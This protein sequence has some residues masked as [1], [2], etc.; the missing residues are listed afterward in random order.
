M[1]TTKLY[2]INSKNYKSINSLNALSSGLWSF[3]NLNFQD[4]DIISVYIS[5]LHAEIP[6]SFYIINENNNKLIIN[7]ITY[8]LIPG[9]YNTK[10]FIE[11]VKALLPIGYI[12]TY[13][14]TT[15]KFTFQYTTLFT[16]SV[17]STCKNIVGLSSS[18]VLGTVENNFTV[19]LPNSFNFLPTAKINIRSSSFNIGNFGAD[20]STDIFLT[21]QNNGLQS[22]RILYQNY[23]NLKYRLEQYNLQQ[24]D[25][26]FTDDSN[27]LLIFNGVDWFITFQ[28]D[29]E[30]KPKE[31]PLSF[32][33]IINSVKR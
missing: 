11:M 16:I 15:N 4:D 6:N 22:G 3:P 14:T 7:S 33:Q 21:V 19:T 25:L 29:I 30:Y 9:N 32:Q 24:F 27:N 1:L 12:I 13:S 28:I 5:I 8:T 23:S 18:D 26:R 20:N 2:N 31:K 10:T 17:L